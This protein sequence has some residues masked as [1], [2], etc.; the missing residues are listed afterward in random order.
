MGGTTHLTGHQAEA[1]AVGTAGAEVRA[2]DGSS[3]RR[4]GAT[5]TRCRG[6]PHPGGHRRLL[7]LRLTR[8]VR[9]PCHEP[10]GR[11]DPPRRD[12]G[13]GRRRTGHHSTPAPLHPH[14]AAVR[15]RGRRRRAAQTQR[16][17]HGI[18]RTAVWLT[19]SLTTPWTTAADPIRLRNRP[20]RSSGSKTHLRPLVRSGS[21]T[22][23]PDSRTH[24]AATTDRLT[25]VRRPAVT[26]SVSRRADGG[27]S[28][29]CH[30]GGEPAR[31]AELPAP[32]TPVARGSGWAR[33]H[34]P[35]AS[36]RVRR[37]GRHRSPAGTH[38]RLITPAGR[39]GQDG[40]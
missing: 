8:P 27:Y 39:L 17:T 34:A 3:G 13:D 7:P 15:T 25:P 30:D 9:G 5:V 24:T 28:Q 40:G 37:A 35:V 11:R 1:S 26:S 16:A 19:S 32:T 14:P 18:R 31:N 38:N 23:Q 36:G 10:P 20:A 2:A 6:R 4:E 21:A 22:W 29:G 33:A 12:R